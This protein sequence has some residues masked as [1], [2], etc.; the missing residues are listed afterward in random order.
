MGPEAVQYGRRCWAL[1][2]TAA[3]RLQRQPLRSAGLWSSP[4]RRIR[5]GELLA[6]HKSNLFVRLGRIKATVPGPPP[7][8]AG[9]LSE[10]PALAHVLLLPASLA[11]AFNRRCHWCCRP[12][13]PAAPAPSLCPPTSQRRR[14]ESTP[15]AL[16]S[17]R[18]RRT[19]QRWRSRTSRMAC[20][21]ARDPRWVQPVARHGALVCAA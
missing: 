12:R 19:T 17:L 16:T 20:K 7:K 14:T 10:Q 21:C 2:P 6:L 18:R 5:T 9:S 13:L 3:C 11:A 15:R 1:V 4:S 8:A